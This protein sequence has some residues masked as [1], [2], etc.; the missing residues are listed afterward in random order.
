M[1]VAV[2]KYHVKMAT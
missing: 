1:T 2:P